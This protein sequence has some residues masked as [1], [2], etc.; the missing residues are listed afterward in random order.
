[1]R[2][3]MM[4]IVVSLATVLLTAVTPAFAEMPWWHLIAGSRP[5][6]LHA[7]HVSEPGQSELQE[8]RLQPNAQFILKVS[9]VK[10]GV[11][12][13]EQEGG[14]YLGTYTSATAA[15]VQAALESPSEYGAGNVEV[16]GV[17]L[18][19]EVK[20]IGADA[21]KAVPSLE[22]VFFIEEGYTGEATASVL[23]PGKA[24]AQQPDGV[25]VASAV[26]VGDAGTSE[27][28]A[29]AAGTGKYNAGCTVEE[30]GM[31][32]FEKEPVTIIDKLP[33]GLK[34]V[35]VE[36]AIQ[37]NGDAQA[38]QC[39]LESLKV[40]EPQSAVCQFTGTDF[41]LGDSVPPY[42]VL[43]VR[44]GVV[45]ESDAS[46]GELNEVSVSGG[47]APAVSVRHPI[48]IS[49]S[50][51]PFGVELYE[52][53]PEEEGGA[54]DTQA[55]SHPFQT[56]FTFSLNQT[57]E[58][59]SGSGTVA[60]NPAGEARDL[61]DLLP[62]GLIGN[63]E[64]FA[65]CTDAQ[66]LALLN[67][68][69]AGS[70]VGAAAVTFSEPDHLGV[71]YQSVPV[72]NLEP[73]FGEPARFGFLPAGRETPVYINAAVRTGGDYGITGEVSNIP[74]TIGF[75]SSVV[76]LWGVPG[77]SRHDETRGYPC[78]LAAFGKPNGAVARGYPA[79]ESLDE[80]EPPPFFELPTSCTGPLQ[81]SVE[82][83]SWERPGMFETTLAAPLP[84]TGGC[85]RLSF[86]P[87][88]EVA[89]SEQETSSPT[90]LIVNVKVPQESS[91]NPKGLGESA[92]RDTVVT[93]PEGVTIDSSGADGLEACSE[94]LVGYEPAISE[95]PG[96]LHFT[97]KLP[98]PLEP[99]LNFCPTASK[100]GTVRIKVP[101]L[102]EP[103]IG[104]VYLAAQ[105][106][107]PFGTLVAMYIEAEDEEAGVLVKLPAEVAL[108]QQTGQIVATLLNS[109][110]A[111]FEEAEFHFFE[112][113]LAALS[114]PA[115]CG[116][117]TTST[118]ITPWSGG[119]TAHPSSSF[120]IMSGPHHSACAN[121]LAF[122]P[123]VIAGTSN[124]QAGAFSPFTATVSREDGNQTLK[125]IQLQLPPGLS[126]IVTGVP[127]CGEAQADAGTCSAGSQVGEATVSVG[128]GAR[129]YTVTGSKLYLTGPYKGAPFGLSIVTPAVAGPYNLGTVVVRAKL[130]INPRTAVA[131]VAS[132]TSGPYAIPKSLDGIP[133]QIK[134]VNATVN[135]PKFTFNPTNCEQLSITGTLGSFEGA[136]ASLSVP[137]EAA[138]CA[139]L[140]FTPKIAVATVAHAS[141]VNG[142]SLHF[143]IA[144]PAGALGTQSWFSE[145]KFDLPKQLPARLET[146]QRACLSTVFETN[147]AACPKASIIGSAIARTPLLPVPVT[148]PVYFVSY[149]G[150]KFPE[151]VIVLNGDNVTVEL[152]GETFIH[153]GITSATF[154]N[155]PDVPFE[156]IEVTIPT[157]RYSEFGAN[158]PPKDN[159]N[160]CG[161]KLTM[162]TLFKAQ[163]GA[164]IHQNTAI[165]INGCKKPKHKT[166]HTKNTK[167]TKKR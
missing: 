133:L 117:Y 44:V 21:D 145:A 14:S 152:H 106:A 16:T 56:S 121:P 154:R 19:L 89:P 139:T 79:C 63:P 74:E 8:L 163:N 38:L 66:F 156:N 134:N 147:R 84:A 124:N 162:P 53:T 20:S 58:T 165:T 113:E 45:V 120:K 90:G 3:T 114:T 27:C 65:R 43:E 37:E 13:S 112:G 32:E 95:P 75:L 161:Q 67:Q 123:T 100:V 24:A 127:L 116:T 144:Y 1:V 54:V 159:Y 93:L 137:F 132:D 94:G 158:L 59:I 167:H 26:N 73:S 98:R 99:G 23:T 149:G 87:T 47:S 108:N 111:P 122:S 70:V 11:F 68:C 155:V 10:A 83:D 60:A 17:G 141:K 46:S 50:A 130:E 28:V 85:N 35:N 136:T 97:A 15:H 33:A 48:T 91:M 34:A 119:V 104:A 131:T 86:D 41:A 110:Q 6:Y 150:A 72:F 129:P 166:K 142:A 61:N 109:P 78:L 148:G 77:D 101:F 102:K 4:V 96:N 138:N 115:Y 80:N 76:T 36:G 118:A 49:G 153:N 107:N 62:P 71:S 151:A 125:S 103:L 146:L 143:K 7:L 5:T 12:E 164:E 105:N 29:V 88:I 140:K 25:M 128:V 57:A 40:G 31:G 69:P 82:A 51:V 92:V 126:G 22:A 42:D 9:K 52:L 81:S 39:K 135:R 30:P 64:P 18:K 157:G 55:G 2:R 160:F